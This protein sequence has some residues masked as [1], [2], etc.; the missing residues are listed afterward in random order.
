MSIE[1]DEI[2]MK[3]PLKNRK[4]GGMERKMARMAK[5]GEYALAI[6][7]FFFYNDSNWLLDEP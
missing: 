4:G 7:R 3:A 6:S 1:F 5:N 2:T